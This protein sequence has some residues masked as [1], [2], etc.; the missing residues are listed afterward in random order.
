MEENIEKKK[1]AKL[2][3]EKDFLLHIKRIVRRFV[4]F[5]IMTMLLLLKKKLVGECRDVG[6]L[7]QKMA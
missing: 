2:L 1:F 7:S 3:L 5:Q 6:I 4:L